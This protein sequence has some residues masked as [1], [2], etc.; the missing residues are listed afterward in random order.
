M[1]IDKNKFERWLR[2]RFAGNLRRI[3]EQ[4]K[5]SQEKLGA[6]CGFHRTYISQV[7]HAV[8]ITLDSL[9]KLAKV[10]EVD[11]VELLSESEQPAKGCRCIDT[12][13]R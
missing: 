9:Q 12:P 2:E 3:R 1:E 13:Q 8:N 7:E 11:P 4:R 5:L 10:L 6:E